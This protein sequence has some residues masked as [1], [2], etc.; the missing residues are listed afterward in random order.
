ML[1]GNSQDSR[2]ER[3]SG[4]DHGLVLD[5]LRPASGMQ[6]PNAIS[7]RA[8]DRSRRAVHQAISAA[9]SDLCFNAVAA[10]VP[11]AMYEHPN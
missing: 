7:N 1:S 9:W 2:R 5:G 11:K 10:L 3:S 8:S 4:I 6:M